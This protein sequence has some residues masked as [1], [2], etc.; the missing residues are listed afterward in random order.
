MAVI[1]EWQEHYISGLADR[2]GTLLLGNIDTNC[3]HETSPCDW[4]RNGR[5]RLYS[6]PIQS[7]GCFTRTRGS[8]CVKRTL[9]MSRMHH[10]SS[11]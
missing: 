8:T 6:L 10:P 4:I 9:Q 5:D 1:P 7:T 11:I 3:V 2:D